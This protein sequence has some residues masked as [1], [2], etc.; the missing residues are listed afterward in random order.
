MRKIDPELL[1]QHKKEADHQYY[2]ANKEK[3][4]RQRDNWRHRNLERVR[5][6]QK[7]YRKSNL[8]A[9]H[10]YELKF[11]QGI[12]LDQ[13]YSMILM[14]EWKCYICKKETSPD[15]LVVDHDHDK[16]KGEG[17]RKLLC[18][19]CNQGL[20]KFKDSSALLFNAAQYL[21]EFGK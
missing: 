8:E 21:E 11:R 2:L 9:H 17:T 3:L 18:N 5:E 7:A 14:Q 19:S 13:K 16:P 20:G 1:K 12:T 4:K 6:N 15:L 10:G